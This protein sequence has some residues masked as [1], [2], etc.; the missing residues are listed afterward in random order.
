MALYTI[1]HN[2]VLRSFA[3]QDAI[4]R[5]LERTEYWVR[6]LRPDADEALRSAAVAHDIERS[7]ADSPA[8]RLL[9]RRS[10]RDPQALT[11]H[12]QR[13]AQIIGDYLI[14]K[15]VDSRQIDRIQDLIRHHEEG[16]SGDR[17]FIKDV[18][19]LS[20]LENNLDYFVTRLL[21]SHGSADVIAK[22]EWMYRR[23]SDRSVQKLA[24]PFY[25]RALAQLRAHSG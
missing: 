12:Q 1:V 11:Y 5:H 6:T 10:F 18:D 13:G 8:N 23:I 16:G 9:R 25:R 17:D 2:F 15:G 20:F 14:Q 19:S 21:P 7:E 4:I 22:F 24:A 3:G